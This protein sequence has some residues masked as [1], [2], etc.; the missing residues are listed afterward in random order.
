MRARSLTFSDA[1]SGY[2]PTLVRLGLGDGRLRDSLCR[3]CRLLDGGRDIRRRGRIRL[4][5]HCSGR[6]DV[7]QGVGDA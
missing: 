5:G 3:D 6:A 7:G 1:F 2:D 4:V